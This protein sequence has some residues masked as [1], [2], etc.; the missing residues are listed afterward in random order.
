MTFMAT[1]SASAGTP[2]WPTTSTETAAPPA[3][4]CLPAQ[5]MALRVSKIRMGLAVGLNRPKPFSGLGSAGRPCGAVH[6]TVGNSRQFVAGSIALTLMLFTLS[7][8]NPVSV[9]LVTSP[10]TTFFSAPFTYR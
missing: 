4:G 7:A 1:S 5:P 10:A 3:T 9:V 8:L 6:V 2:A